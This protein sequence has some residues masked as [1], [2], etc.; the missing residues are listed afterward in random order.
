MLKSLKSAYDKAS[1]GPADKVQAV[2]ALEKQINDKTPNGKGILVTVDTNGKLTLRN[3]ESVNSGEPHPEFAGV[4]IKD[5]G[6]RAE[7]DLKDGS[8]EAKME[9]PR[10]GVGGGTDVVNTSQFP[11]DALFYKAMHANPEWA[12]AKWRATNPG[13]EALLKGLNDPKVASLVGKLPPDILD[14]AAGST[15]KVNDFLQEK[16]FGR[17]LDESNPAEEAVAGTMTIKRDW[18]ASKDTVTVGDKTYPAIDKGDSQIYNVNGRPVVKLFTGNDGLTVYAIPNDKP[19]TGFEAMKDAKSLV[20]KA[21]ANGPS[22]EGVVRIPMVDLSKTEKLGWM[23]GLTDGER[24]ISQAVMQ[25]TLKMDENGF[26]ARQ[27]LAMGATRGLHLRPEPKYTF[28][29]DFTFVVAKDG[30]PIFVQ[31]VTKE[32]WKDPKRQ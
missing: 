9:R 28:N 27:A 12:A 16:G 2:K 21:E 10:P 1:G 15:K 18:H 25:T 22:D 29:T 31:P 5:I 19:V 32:S 4:F 14:A 6:T 7:T 3:L 26:D 11:S 20:P 8:T 30:Q 13:Q 23:L 24:R 17:L